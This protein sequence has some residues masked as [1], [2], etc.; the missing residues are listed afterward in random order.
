VSTSSSDIAHH[1][2]IEVTTTVKNVSRKPVAYSS[3]GVRH[4]GG[5]NV[6]LNNK[7]LQI[8]AS[9]PTVEPSESKLAPGARLWFT[10]EFYGDEFIPGANVLKAKWQGKYSADLTVFAKDQTAEEKRQAE[11]CLKG[12]AEPYCVL[13]PVSLQDDYNRE[14]ASCDELHAPI[15]ILGISPYECRSNIVEDI[16]YTVPAADADGWE[17]RLLTIKQVS[18]VYGPYRSDGTWRSFEN[19][20]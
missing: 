19:D 12:Q 15:A 18:Y 6:V 20:K 11:K 13:L 9:C 14:D 17:A 3:V 8:V 4:C 2:K 7:K 16:T 1:D 5:P 10:D